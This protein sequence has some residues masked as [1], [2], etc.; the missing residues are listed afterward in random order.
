MMVRRARGY[1]PRPVLRTSAAVRDVLAL[2]SGL[3]NTIC[4]LKRGV[5]VMSQHLG[6]LRS[7]ASLNAF[8]RT[9]EA[10]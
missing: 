3:K 4:L 6:D 1:A 8:E 7:A 5:A 9:V 10:L 2:G